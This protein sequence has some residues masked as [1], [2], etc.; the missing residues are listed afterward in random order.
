MESIKKKTSKISSLENGWQ[1]KIKKKIKRIIF[2][3]R[4]RNCLQAV[5]DIEK[6]F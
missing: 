3:R 1:R 2:I 4:Y 5:N 6:W